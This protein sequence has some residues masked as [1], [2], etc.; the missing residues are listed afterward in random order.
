MNFEILKQHR[1]FGGQTLFCEHDSKATGTKMR[2][3]VYLP[4]DWK[5][6]K[7]S[8]IWLSG[9]TCTEENFITKS[10]IQK[11]LS[12][13]KAAIFC[14]DTSPRGLNLPGEDESYDFGSGAS[15]YLNAKKEPFAQNYQMESYIAEEFYD[16]V[17][18]ATGTKG[19]GIFGHSMGGHG[20]LTLGLKYPE[21]FKTISAFSPI[22][23]PSA[24]P[25]GQ[26]AFRGYLGDNEDEWKNHDAVE[27]LKNGT[28]P[29]K[30]LIHQGLDD[31]FYEKELLTENFENVADEVG[32]KYE[33]RKEVGYDHSYYFISTFLDEHLHHHLHVL[34]STAF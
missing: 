17:H 14:P 33:I 28:H 19:I 24:S 5:D 25:W 16:L 2:F 18:E 12:I 4:C 30:I 13:T 8:L 1:T 10:G 6:I 3:S 7:C 34:K 21:K 20:A 9:L 22:M 29:N 11:A 26:K 27:L 32:Q 31:E 15:F 23:N